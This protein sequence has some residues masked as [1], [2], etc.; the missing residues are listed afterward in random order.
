MTHACLEGRWEE[1]LAVQRRLHPLCRALFT[2]TNP[3]GVKGA[4]EMMGL[5][6][7]ELRLPMT[8]MSEPN[9]ESVRTEL[10][11]LGLMK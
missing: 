9:L 3:I 5:I 10:Q 1:A 4:L 2:E 7:G 11:N 6:T 8:P